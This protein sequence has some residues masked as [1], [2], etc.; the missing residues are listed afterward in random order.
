[1][2]K[3]EN[4]KKITLGLKAGKTPEKMD[5]ALENG[6][7]EFIFGLGPEGMSPFEYE[8]LDK[9]EGEEV[10]IGLKKDEMNMFFEHLRL[11]V[12]NLFENRSHVFLT[13]KINRIDLAHNREIVKALADIAGHGKGSE[14][15][16]GC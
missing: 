16:C 9:T 12:M 10:L 2:K 14:C 8:L 5:L 6:E 13:F 4:L 1:M 7:F 11:P 15:G 3:I